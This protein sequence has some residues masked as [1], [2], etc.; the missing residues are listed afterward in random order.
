MSKKAFTYLF[1]CI[2]LLFISA[3]AWADDPRA[4][5]SF[6][7]GYTFSDGVS[8]DQV[9]ALNGN[10]YDRIDTK[11]SFSWGFQGEVFI[12]P[13]AEVGFRYNR[14]QSKLQAGG[15]A[16]TEI[17]DI[18]VDDYHGI[19]SY[20]FGDPEAVTRPFFMGGIGATHFGGLTFTAFDG[21]SRSISGETKFSGLIGGGIKLYPAPNF[22][23]RLQMTW[24]PTYIK[25]DSAGWWCDPYW[26]CYAVGNAQYSNQIE[27]AGGVSLR[28]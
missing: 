1:I 7:V 19:F 9:H 25:S 14:Q 5:V 4:E 16:T 23:V 27:M 28:F 8:G 24:V 20:N 13:N 22:G 26:G 18:H 11:D 21:S 17:G 10:I 3:G 2:S 12:S 15:T 6:L